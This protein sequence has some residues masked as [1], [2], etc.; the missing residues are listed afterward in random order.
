MCSVF[1]LTPLSFPDTF[2]RLCFPS[3]QSQQPRTC[4][5]VYVRVFLVV[6]GRNPGETALVPGGRWTALAS[7]G[8]V[9]ASDKTSSPTPRAHA[10]LLYNYLPA[11]L[12]PAGALTGWLCEDRFWCPCVGV[13]SAGPR[14]P[15]SERRAAP[16]PQLL[17][18]LERLCF[19]ESRG[20]ESR[21]LHTCGQLRL[22]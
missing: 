13:S 16:G 17:S 18:A 8:G 2:C 1:S 5:G 10:R 11:G 20:V 12:S 4:S 22:G 9:A 21:R 3:R 19:L 14:A 7:A 15:W 6:R